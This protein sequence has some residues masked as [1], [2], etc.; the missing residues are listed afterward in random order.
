MRLAP[1][2]AAREGEAAVRA[3]PQRLGEEGE[4]SVAKASLGGGAPSGFRSISVS[5]RR[6][7]EDAKGDTE[8][9]RRRAAD[10]AKGD[11]EPTR[12]READSEHED[13]EA[14]PP[15]NG[16]RKSDTQASILLRA[17]AEC[18]EWVEHLV[19]IASRRGRSP[20]LRTVCRGVRERL[21]QAEANPARSTL[22]EVYARFDLAG[23]ERI[24]EGT[25]E[26]MYYVWRRG[27]RDDELAD[28]LLSRLTPERLAAKRWH[29]F[30]DCMVLPMP[31]R[32]A[33]SHAAWQLCGQ[34]W[35][36]EPRRYAALIAEPRHAR[37]VAR[38]F[39]CMEYRVC[40]VPSLSRQE[41]RKARVW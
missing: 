18:L 39:L 19:G 36:D 28:D 3:S 22:S 32:A 9:P 17:P 29:R 6:V 33:L 41:M 38:L 15:G 40:G 12:R 27:K 30:V 1:W 21:R 10:D 16:G 26:G 37:H 23:E 13:R 4:E 35:R 20:A 11:T 31:G 2:A 7:S 25:P 8:P 5:R 14:R 24:P 34:P